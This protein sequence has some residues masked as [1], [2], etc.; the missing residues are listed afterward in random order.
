MNKKQIDVIDKANAI[1]YPQLQE[2]EKKVGSV[3]NDT[4]NVLK[5]DNFYFPLEFRMNNTVINSIARKYLQDNEDYPSPDSSDE[6]FLIGTVACNEDSREK[7]NCP[8][9]DKVS[10]SV[11]ES[12]F[13]D[14]NNIV[15]IHLTDPDDSADYHS[16]GFVILSK[17]GVYIRNTG[18]S[19][20]IEHYDYRDIRFTQEGIESV[21]RISM[22]GLL[23]NYPLNE[24]FLAFAQ[25]FILLR[26]T[27]LL[28][29]S[30]RHPFAD[31]FPE[32]RRDYLEIL[33][34]VAANEG[35]LTVEK[36]IRLEYI[37]REFKIAPQEF[38]QW[39]KNSL[40][41]VA[42][43]DLQKKFREML[44]QKTKTDEWYVLFQDILEMAVCDNG[45]L[46]SKKIIDLLKRKSNAGENFVTNYIEFI[47]MRRQSELFLHKAVESVG[48]RN[49]ADNLG[50]YL[51]K[52]HRLQTY[53]NE[54]NLKLLDIGVLVNEK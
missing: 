40:R 38:E 50:G 48:Y 47:K 29:M 2:N 42:A 33:V 32:F 19:N 22:E 3:K 36:Y 11:S 39:L 9:M 34:S 21:N 10:K 49:L 12:K 28:L 5:K 51:K 25:E 13:I 53:T 17:D 30:E 4:L 54:M 7:L 35:N 37:A 20:K 52:I 1:I 18:E 24:N 23:L 6:R 31:S 26:R 45:E 8:Y 16:Q 44:M 43:N 14:K 27:T 41:N 46:N 15:A